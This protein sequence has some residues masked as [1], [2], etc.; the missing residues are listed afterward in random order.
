MGVGLL[1]PLPLSS[2]FTQS[3]PYGGAGD[4]FCEVVTSSSSWSPSIPLCASATNG[5]HVYSIV[6]L[7]SEIYY[8]TNKFG[9]EP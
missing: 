8:V 1:H 3:D 2:F 7:L 5:E 4:E 6:H 9:T